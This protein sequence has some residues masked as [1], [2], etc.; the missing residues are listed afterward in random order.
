M[1][2]EI[3]SWQDFLDLVYHE[4]LV[5][6][7]YNDFISILEGPV[8]PYQ[9][10]KNSTDHATKNKVVNER[11]ETE[12]QGAGARVKAVEYAD[13]QNSNSCTN[14]IATDFN[15]TMG[16]GL[17]LIAKKV[18]EHH[19][20]TK[21]CY[22]KLQ[23]RL[24]G[25]QAIKLAQLFYR[26]VDCLACENESE[27]QKLLRLALSKIGQMLRDAGTLFNKINCNNSDLELLS[28]TPSIYYNLH[29][30]FFPDRVTL[31]VWTMGCALRYHANKLYN[32]FSIGY[33]IV[34]CQSKEAKHASVKKDL[35]LSNRH[36]SN[37]VS[38]N[39]WW[40]VFRA[41]YI[42]CFYIPE[43]HPQPCSFSSH[44]ASCVPKQCSV[45]GVCN[46]GRD[47]ISGYNEC[48]TCLDSVVVVECAKNGEMSNSVTELILPMPCS[49]CTSRFSDKASLD[50]HN[51][52]VHVSHISHLTS[53]PKTMSKAALVA[54][55]R[56]RGLSTKGSV[57]VLWQ[58]LLGALEGED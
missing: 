11:S 53:D 44:Y 6:G 21:T 32:E 34:S 10:L 49:C 7:Q 36:M 22:N 47:C 30:L 45:E 2:C 42:Q 57:G 38:D 16:V 3:N 31:T 27:A 18:K 24:I 29:A 23:V 56:K 52:T 9:E 46:C 13:K 15:D 55:L 12:P 43:F 37:S 20:N 40:Q 51:K 50:V 41:E 58:R 19:D 1:H 33:G 14:H 48:K 17:P 4:S 35:S 39:K 28:E 54:E 8:R 5:R 26:L 25:A